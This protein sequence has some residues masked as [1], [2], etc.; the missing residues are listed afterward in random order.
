[1]N[2]YWVW[3]SRLYKI[4]A[5]KQ[6]MLIIKY[7][8][9]E[10][11]WKLKRKDLVKID[12]LKE[13]DV[14][15]ILNETYRQNLEKYIEYMQKNKIYLITINDKIY[16]ENL[17]KIYDPPVVIYVKGNKEIL[18]KTSISIIGSRNCSNYGM[19]VAKKFAYELAARNIIVVSRFSKRNRC[20]CT[21]WN[22]KI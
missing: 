4:G 12:F 17:R 7:G 14:D 11:I 19:T 6:N 22:F 5:Y 10:E 21:L 16:P 2:K 13:D 8:R 3:L 9:P 1:M 18:N 15:I 20:I